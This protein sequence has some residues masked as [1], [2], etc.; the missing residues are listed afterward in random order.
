MKAFRGSLAV[1]VIVL[2]LVGVLSGSIALV[3]TALVLAILEVTLS[4]DNAVVNAKYLKKM[5]PLWQKLFLTVGILIAVF[6][7]RLVFPILIVALTADL[8]FTEVIDLALNDVDTYA[9]ELE[10]AKPAIYSFGGVFLLMIF[11][12]WIFEERDIKWLRP[13]EAALSKLGRLDQLSVVIAAVLILLASRVVDEA[14]VNTVLFSGFIGLVTYLVVSGL[15]SFFDTDDDEEV[16]EEH[17]VRRGGVGPAVATA[18]KAGFSTF[19]YLEVLDASFSFDGVIGAFA[20]STNVLVIAAGL[21]IGALFV[22]SMTVYL[23]RQGTLAEYR[24]LEHGAHWAIG[25][26]AIILIIELEFHISE[27]VT[28]LLGLGFILAAYVSSIVAN[29]RDAREL[30]ENR[31]ADHGEGIDEHS[32]V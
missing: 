29:K 32:R 11:L 3:A 2:V 24:Y 22:R 25:A 13:L 16:D 28:G 30:L 1:S 15:D 6:G 14:E 17:V 21:G 18:G 8:G 9:E 26:L 12:D 20:I 27:F 4:F 10:G 31:G 5:T 19:L 7:M 23:V